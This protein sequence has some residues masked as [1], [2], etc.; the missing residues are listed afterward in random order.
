[1]EK[2]K[3]I[4]ILEILGRPAD[5]VKES[6]F[7]L[8]DSLGKEKGIK[9]LKRSVA[10]SKKVEGKEM[11]STFAEIEVETENI[12]VLFDIM[13]RYMPAHIEI[14]EPT[15]MRME[16]ADLDAMLS[17][18]IFKLHR[19]D[20]LAKILTI[21][22]QILTQQVMHMRKQLGIDEQAPISPLE[23]PASETKSKEKKAKKSKA[24]KK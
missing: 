4:M 14:L 6:A 8:V 2:I 17:N 5:Y 7:V 18:L 19:Y 10:D 3:A 11:F 22:K 12:L 20:E 23:N 24:K 1:M 13:F 16:S 21:E 9:I 15:D